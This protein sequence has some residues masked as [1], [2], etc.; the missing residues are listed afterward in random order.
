[1]PVEWVTL[2]FG[3]NGRNGRMLQFLSSVSKEDGSKG[4]FRN[5]WVRVPLWG[6]PGPSSVETS[7]DK[8][9]TEEPE[10]ALEQ[11]VLTGHLLGEF[12]NCYLIAI[13]NCDRTNPFAPEKNTIGVKLQPT[14]II[15]CILAAAD[16]LGGAR[17]TWI[18]WGKDGQPLSNLTAPHKA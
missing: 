15:Q 9:R 7:G 13:T 6:R 11:G 8:H 18:V 14:R 5:R 10:A 4:R 3:M 12:K 2:S 1:M 17:P 16:L